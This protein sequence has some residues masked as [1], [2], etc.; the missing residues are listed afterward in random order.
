MVWHLLE[1]VDKVSS[2]YMGLDILSDAD[3]VCDPMFFQIGILQITVKQMET[4]N[5]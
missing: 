2:D 5:R 1:F 3:Y 4:K